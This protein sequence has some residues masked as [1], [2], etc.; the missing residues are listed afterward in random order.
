VELDTTLRS[1]L[2]ERLKLVFEDSYKGVQ[3][4]KF[5][6]DLRAYERFMWEMSADA[7]VEL[8]VGAG[9]STLW[10][11]DRLAAATGG[12][13]VI[14]VDVNP[15]PGLPEDVI[16]VQ[17]DIRDSDLPDRVAALLPADARPFIVEDTAHTYE[18]TIA[19]LEGFSRLVPEGGYFVVEDAVVDIDDLRMLEE[20]PRGVRQALDDWLAR[21]P[22]FSR[23]PA[24]YIVTCHPVGFLRAN[25]APG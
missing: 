9:G 13:V 21:N 15:D 19:A 23:V 1:Y 25:A 16:Y 10:F 11:R 4:L 20:W 17:A 14:A 8:G 24:P 6:E 3:M 12:G 22:R 18:T 7:V 5:P 2:R